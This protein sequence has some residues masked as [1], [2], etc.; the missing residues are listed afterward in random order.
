MSVSV[1]LGVPAKPE[2]IDELIEMF[3]GNSKQTRV[4]EGCID[5]YMTRAHED[6]N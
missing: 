5:V 2:C 3:T 1:L 6:S 4:Y